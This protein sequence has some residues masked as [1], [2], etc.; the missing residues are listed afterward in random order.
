MQLR[1]LASLLEAMDL[2]GLS[3]ESKEVAERLIH[4]AS[5]RGAA[6]PKASQVRLEFSSRVK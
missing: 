2:S 1:E 3:Q 5:Q 6:S 4:A